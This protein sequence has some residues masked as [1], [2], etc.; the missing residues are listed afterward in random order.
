MY[1][2]RTALRGLG[3]PGWAIPG[4]SYGGA[5]TANTGPS[6]DIPGLVTNIGKGA[7]D[8]YKT[9]LTTEAAKDIAESQARAAVA[10]APVTPL[11]R[12]SSTPT[13]PYQPA[14]SGLT[15]GM[16]TQTLM[17][18]LGLG[19]AGLLGAFLLMRR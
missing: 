8:L 9:Y 4:A 15:A 1:S 7:A 13:Y 19:G 12:Y 3:Q 5:T 16:S 18:L 2:R 10:A 6:I 17:L 14:Y 11:Y